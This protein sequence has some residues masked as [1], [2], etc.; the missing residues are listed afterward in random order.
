MV[1]IGSLL[2]AQAAD[3]CGIFG[4]RTLKP[5][6]YPYLTEERVL[7]VWDQ[8]THREHFVREVRFDKANQRFGF[9]IPTPTR[10]AVKKVEKSPFPALQDGLP[11]EVSQ[12]GLGLVGNMGNGGG[13]KM[14]SLGSGP[15]PVEVLAVQR[16]GKF[17]AFTLA[18]HEASAFRKWLDDNQFGT[19]ADVEKWLAHYIE[20]GFYF[21]A[22]RYDAKADE[23]P[24]MSS[25]VLDVSFDTELPFYP[26]FE[27]RAPAGQYVRRLT[28]WFVSQEKMLPVGAT[29]HDGK[30]ELVR[31]WHAGGEYHPTPKLLGAAMPEFASILPSDKPE[32]QVQVFRDRKISRAEFHDVV[33]V[34][35]TPKS[36]EVEKQRA[37]MAWLDPSMF[38]PNG[39]AASAAP[40]A[41][42]SASTS[43]S[44]SAS[45]SA[46]ASAAP[47]SGPKGSCGV[48][49]RGDV[50]PWWIAPVLVALRRRRRLWGAL[51]IGAALGCKREPAPVASSAPGSA[52]P[53]VSAIPISLSASGSSAPS[54]AFVPRLSAEERKARETLL[55]AAFA[56]TVPSAVRLEAGP[57]AD[58][59]PQSNE[60]KLES[61]KE[62][63]VEVTG[64]LPENVI[65]RIVRANFGRFRA[66]YQQGLKADPSL[67]GTVGVRFIINLQGEVES[68]KSTG[69]TLSDAKVVT[70]VVGVFLRLAYPEPEQKKVMVTYRLDFGPG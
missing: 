50:G 53:S 32:L 18:A 68:A 56:G 23:M 69:G 49:A 26:Y 60:K 9:V 46:S 4:S 7:I 10:P 31:P 64:P 37:M 25:E 48:G 47:V 30:L 67:Q 1:S 14:S 51:A 16:L 22:L 21:V 44:A 40:A 5:F 70:C 15:P 55:L 6:E 34:P 19:D 20:S 24:G 61:I 59:S 42:T 36:G 52:A 45:T 28:T 33:F 39:A 41:S 13:G 17:D 63:T 27:P 12:G 3:A 62:G 66:C 43:A 38:Q 57:F 65:L 11:F 54:V 29:V 8:Q 35:T 2:T 58:P